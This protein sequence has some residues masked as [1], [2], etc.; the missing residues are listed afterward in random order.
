M[1]DWLVW[2]KQQFVPYFLLTQ[3]CFLQETSLGKREPENGARA[4]GQGNVRI[5]R[6][7]KWRLKNGTQGNPGNA[8]PCPRTSSPESKLHPPSFPR[9]LAPASP[10]PASRG[11]WLA[12][13]SQVEASRGRQFCSHGQSASSE[14][15][16]PLRAEDG[17]R[18][19][20]Q[21]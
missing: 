11:T 3:E 7:W 6:N 20:T 5:V 9:S 17:D 4:E 15:S 16:R 19:Q 18:S 21:R 2:C 8:H 14:R 10:A 12:G 13:H 1:D